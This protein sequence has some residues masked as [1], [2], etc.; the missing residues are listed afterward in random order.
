MGWVSKFDNTFWEVPPGGTSIWTGSEW[1]FPNP[2]INLYIQVKGGSTWAAGYRP[3]QI[4]ITAYMSSGGT[5]SIDLDTFDTGGIDQLAGAVESITAAPTAFT[6]TL[7]FTPGLDIDQIQPFQAGMTSW[8]MRITDI[9]F[10]E[11]A[12]PTEFWTDKVKCS[13]SDS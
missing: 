4:R 5:Q 13:E 3:T 8:D 12:G 11:G 1:S 6:Y 2:N 7:D 10:L 9:E